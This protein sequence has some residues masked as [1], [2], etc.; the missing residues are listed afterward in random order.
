MQLRFQEFDG[1]L[2]LYKPCGI[3]TH[4]VADNQFGFVEYLSEKLNKNL[5]VVHR[6]DKET[7]GLILFAE[8]KIMAQKISEL[9]ESQQIK[10]T[11]YFLTSYEHKNTRFSIKTHIEKQENF[12]INNES[13]EPNSETHF[14]FIK[15]LGQHHLWQAQPQ[16]GKPHQIRLHAQKAGIAI[17][18]DSQH[19]GDIFHR[20]ALHAHRIEF[21]LNQHS[22]SIESALPDL[23]T[24]N[25]SSL[26]NDCYFDRHQLYKILPHESY[27]LIHHEKPLLRADIFDD[28]LWVYDYSENGL[29]DSETIEIKSF[30]AEKKLIL[31]VRHML[32]RGQGVGG[33]EQKTLE[34][35]NISNWIAQEEGVKYQLKLNSGFSPGLFLD[36]RENRLWIKKTAANKKVLNLFSYTS[37]FSVNAALAPASQVTSVDVSKKFLDWS[38]ENFVLNEL[39]P[40]KFEFFSQDTVLFLKGSLKR[41]R[42]WDLIIC[43]P[44]SFG[45]AQDSVWKLESHLPELA[46]L[47]FNCLEPKGKILFTCNLEKRSRQE[48]INLFTK[49]IKS[50]NYRIIRMPMLSLDYELT[51][52]LS[53]LMKGFILEKA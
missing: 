22:Y 44:P 36:Q 11:Y 9:F 48:I 29:T 8:T 26:F 49:N 32:N 51:D 7:S 6:L 28:R 17:L 10:K 21:S 34:S 1:F 18:G 23:F 45:R 16:T 50:Q 24:Q 46:E 52:D 47:L 15:K 43:D 37:G 25:F 53:N 13:K 39:D 19:G 31:V 33:L 40:S 3:R 20:L 4:R 38:R 12:F 5:L 2:A 41:N 27:R 42:K 35:Q 30:A 14:L